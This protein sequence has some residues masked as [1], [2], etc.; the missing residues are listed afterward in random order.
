M[1]DVVSAW[2]RRRGSSMA[3]AQADLIGGFGRGSCLVDCS[4]STETWWRQIL[5][6]KRLGLLVLW[7]MVLSMQA[8]TGCGNS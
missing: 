2:L 3:S 1:Q 8:A 7:G 4:F 5:T 6:K